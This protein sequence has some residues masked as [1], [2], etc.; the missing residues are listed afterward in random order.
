MR[1]DLVTQASPEQVLDAMTDFTDRRLEIWH[2]LDPKVYEVRESGETWAVAR[3]KARRARPTGSSPGTTG[4]I[5]TWSAGPSWRPTTATR[6]ADSC[7]SSRTGRAAVSS[8]SSGAPV[9]SACGTRWP[10]GCCTA[11]WVRSSPGCGAR[12]W[13]GWLLHEHRRTCAPL[14][15]SSPDGRRGAPTGGTQRAGD[16]CLSESSRPVAGLLRTPASRSTATGA[17]DGSGCSRSHTW[18]SSCGT[19]VPSATSGSSNGTPTMWL[20]RQRCDSSP[21]A[22]AQAAISVR[23]C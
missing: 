19:T 23:I 14:A 18:P 20:G 7:G 17:A 13:I 12:T 11:R 6:E 2:T 15:P 16:P 3:G 22:H 9:R 1:F 8:T 5:R 4:R 21:T 10:S